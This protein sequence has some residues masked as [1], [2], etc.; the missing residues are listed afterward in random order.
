MVIGHIRCSGIKAL[1]S[2]KDGA[3]DS[4]HFIEDWV[5]IGF[6][7]KKKANPSGCLDFRAHQ[8][9]R[10]HVVSLLSPQHLLPPSSRP[11]RAHPGPA[12]PEPSPPRPFI[13]QPPC[14]RAPGGEPPPPCR[15]TPRS[16][17]PAV[18]SS[19]PESQAQHLAAASPLPTGLVA[20]SPPVP[21][22]PP[23]PFNSPGT[24]FAGRLL[25]GHRSQPQLR[26]APQ[27]L[28]KPP[29][30]L[31]PW[32][33]PPPALLLDPAGSGAPQVP[34]RP[35]DRGGRFAE[36]GHLTTNRPRGPA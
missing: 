32:E 31:P 19:S 9:S 36:A 3:D 17:C 24:S 35:V 30:L 12:R 4:F 28:G 26:P 6:P 25:G 5:R 14:S 16:P 21:F 18:G 23:R 29:R 22:L 8:P 27:R 7:A 34:A 1:L 2:L 15:V 10:R 13:P 11:A 33:E 20:A